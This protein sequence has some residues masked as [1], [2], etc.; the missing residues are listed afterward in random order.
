MIISGIYFVFL[1]FFPYNDEIL[2]LS[3]D[4]LMI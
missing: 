3:Q 4:E 2:L 1:L